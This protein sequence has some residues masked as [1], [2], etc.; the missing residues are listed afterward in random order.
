ME[1]LTENLKLKYE[2]LESLKS[3]VDEKLAV[4]TER[5]E[6]RSLPHLQV[7]KT[8]YYLDTPPPTLRYLGKMS[9]VLGMIISSMTG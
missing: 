4:Q 3:K 8:R 7:D 6:G 1:E 5:T 9:M 2:E